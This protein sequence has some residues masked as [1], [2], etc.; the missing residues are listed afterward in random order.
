[1]EETYI[2]RKP[3]KY[4]IQCA[5]FNC[6]ISIF[7]QYKNSNEIKELVEAKDFFSNILELSNINLESSNSSSSDDFETQLKSS[8]NFILQR[9]Y[10]N[11]VEGYLSIIEKNP[12]WND[13]IAKDELL[14]LF[15]FLGNNNSI[16]I[17]GR[18]R[19]LNILYK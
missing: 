9:N 17:N 1:M 18:S 6:L 3:D 13:G 12:K 5:Y 2:S 10:D 11:A 15:S 8:R 7:Y 19:L 4:R 16:T 14:R